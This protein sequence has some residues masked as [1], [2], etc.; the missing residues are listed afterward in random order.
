[1]RTNRNDPFEDEAD[2]ACRVCGDVTDLTFEHF[3]PKS[4][5]NRRKI[6][7]L[8][9]LSWLRRE[10]EG[11][12]AK[13]KII[14]QGSG[15]YSLC[16]A[17][18]NQ[19]G[20]LYVPELRNWVRIGNAALADLDAASLDMEVDP[21]YAHLTIEDVRPA[22][23]MKQMATMILALAPGGVARKN[24]ELQNYAKDP[25]AVGLP[26][27]YQFYLA[28]NAGPNARYNGGSVAMTEAGL[29][30]ALELS[31]PPFTYILS[32]DEQ[33]PPIE[34]G[35]ITSFTEI[36]FDQTARVEMQLRVGF[37]HTAL[38]LD[39]RSR[40]ALDRDIAANEADAAAMADLSE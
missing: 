18:N 14:Q 30:F 13:G 36:R 10:D 31:F 8:D 6:E 22:R 26:S 7:M 32:I 35:N 19:S 27:K 12:E 2:S 4:T 1:M 34:T 16:E 3:P 37:S 15:A 24:S 38:P 23:F 20:R 17:C 25:A 21:S 28:L 40:A 9:V 29:V 33:T 5:G 39:L 11:V